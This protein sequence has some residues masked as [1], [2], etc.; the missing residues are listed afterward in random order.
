M[1]EMKSESDLILGHNNWLF[2]VIWILLWRDD[3]D[4]KHQNLNNNIS[5]KNPNFRC[6]H[7]DLRRDLVVDLPGLFKWFA[8]WVWLAWH[9]RHVLVGWWVLLAFWAHFWLLLCI[10]C[11]LVIFGDIWAYL[12]L[13]SLVGVVTRLWWVLEIGRVHHFLSSGSNYFKL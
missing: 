10:C 12:A 7:H 11:I 1:K 13:V 6:P 4:S 3:Q 9:M 5:I 8:T 2:G